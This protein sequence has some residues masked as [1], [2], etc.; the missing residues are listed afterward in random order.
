MFVRP[1]EAQD[2]AALSALM[3]R[4]I[5]ETGARD[6]SP[7]QVKAWASR[8]PSAERL[9]EI[10]SDGRNGLVALDDNGAPLAFCDLEA[11]GHIDYLYCA[12]HA[13]GT[14]VAS[15][16]YER[17]ETM[18]H[19]H[20]LTRLYIEASEAARRFFTSKGFATVKRRDFEIGGVAIHNFLMTKTL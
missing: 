20:G 2:A 13:I 4:A 10:Y 18:A 7:A 17:L 8:V 19:T 16:L 6:Y 9:H 5:M 12:P 1:Y 11:D 14:G 3:L 15:A